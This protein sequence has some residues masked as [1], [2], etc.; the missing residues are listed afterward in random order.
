MSNDHTGNI[1]LVDSYIKKHLI[2]EDEGLE[3]A[4]TNSIKQGLP[5]IAVSAAQGKFASLL[6]TIGSARNVLEIG[7]LGGYS[8]IWFAKALKGRGRVTSIEAAPHHRDVA[9]DNLRTAG[10]QVP[11]E[12]DVLLGAGLDVLPKLAVEIERGAREPFDFVF[13]D[14][15]W[16][17][18][19]NYFEFGVKLSKGTGAVIYID[20]VVQN[21]LESGIVGENERD[22]EAIDVVAKAGADDRVDAVVMQTVGSKSHDGFLLAVVK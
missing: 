12:V 8:T 14:A 11:E 1:N 21:M 6:T 9:I 17:N 2:G 5:I 19:W 7:T 13:I 16:P 18:Q 20:N 10:V 22:E 3:N 4:Y 15:D